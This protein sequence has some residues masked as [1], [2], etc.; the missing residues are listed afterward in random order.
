MLETVAGVVLALLIALVAWTLVRLA[1][2]LVRLIRLPRQRAAVLTAR[3]RGVRIRRSR[4]LARAEGE[5]AAA[6]AEEVRHL[7]AELR[8]ARAERNEALGRVAQLE[9][10]DGG[11]FWRRRAGPPDDRFLRA[12]REFARRFHP[13]RLVRGAP[14]RAMR[15]V[16]F[17]EFWSALKQ[18]E[19]GR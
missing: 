16:I 8:L 17:T 5:R 13:D 9:G 7:R 11:R 3:M 6:L 10:A 2:A 19:R 14:D 15:A 1:R 4:A 12:K 18:I